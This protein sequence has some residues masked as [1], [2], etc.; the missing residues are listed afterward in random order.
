MKIEFRKIPYTKSD[1]KITDELLVC[2]G[3][4]FKESNRI[5]R[6]DIIMSG[7]TTIDCD[8]CGEPFDLEID[9]K[10]ELKVSDGVSEEEDLDIIE[11]Q[12]HFIGF[13]DI[14]DS[15]IASIKSDYHYCKK[16]K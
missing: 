11:C 5:V 10:Q 13:D 14:I 4:F 2:D 16:C 8:I 12:D 1:F 3:T 9:E 7:Q 6:V 15:E